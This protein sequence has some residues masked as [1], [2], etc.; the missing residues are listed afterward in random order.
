MKAG[1]A[2]VFTGFISLV[3]FTLTAGCIGSGPGN[4][5]PSPTP[6]FVPTASPKPESA[7]S[8]ADW[9]TDRDVYA[10]NAAATGWV[11]VTNTG[12]A[13]IDGID[14]TVVI[15][16]IILLI[17]VEKTFSHNA[18]GLDIQPGETEKVLF[19]VVERFKNHVL[20]LLVGQ[21]VT[22]LHADF[23]SLAAT[24]LACAH[25]Q[26]PVGINEELNFNARQSSGHR[27]YAFQIEACQ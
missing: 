21:A 14:F 15:K 5:G 12:S 11:N 3:L 7:A 8:L 22:R 10:S 4:E 23:G 2:I 6:A 19:S 1:P 25:V 20:D 27:R 9:G 13:P 17:P 26:Y 24:L 16:R 18:T